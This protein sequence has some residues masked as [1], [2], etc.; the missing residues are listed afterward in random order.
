MKANRL[1][2]YLLLVLTTAA[3]FLPTQTEASN[4]CNEPGPISYNL[5]M[6]GAGAVAGIPAFLSERGRL[7]VGYGMGTTDAPPSAY[8]SQSGASGTGHVSADSGDWGY[9][10]AWTS[11]AATDILLD[12]CVSGFHQLS[13]TPWYTLVA[14]ERNELRLAFG[15]QASVI[16]FPSVRPGLKLG[17]V[18]L[19]RASEQ[20][21]VATRFAYLPTYLGPAPDGAL[22]TN[23]PFRGRLRVAFPATSSVQPT[24]EIEAG[25]NRNGPFRPA[26]EHYS[27]VSWYLRP[28]VLLRVG[29]GAAWSR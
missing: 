4:P 5:Q 19:W 8:G 3:T 26:G 9:E 7:G 17:L 15:P 25:A 23:H 2:H 16:D 18:H 1:A 21:A 13:G 22:V 29:I 12:S 14:G 28:Y 10:V 20:L 11:H 6:T 24:L 27:R